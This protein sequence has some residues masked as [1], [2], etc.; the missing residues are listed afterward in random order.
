MSFT[1]AGSGFMSPLTCVSDSAYCPAHLS[2]CRLLYVA[3]DLSLL[4]PPKFDSPMRV[5][6]SLCSAPSVSAIASYTARL[7]AGVGR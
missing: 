3:L 7:C 5:G 1:I 4:P 6:S 2:S